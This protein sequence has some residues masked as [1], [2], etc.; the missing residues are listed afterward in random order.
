MLLIN[1]GVSPLVRIPA[2]TLL[3]LVDHRNP[4]IRVHVVLGIERIKYGFEDGHPVLLHNIKFQL[5]KRGK[6]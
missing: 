1:E 2:V 3:F 6:Y 4:S 5:E